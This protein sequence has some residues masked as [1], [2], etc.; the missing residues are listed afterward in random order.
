MTRA[1]LPPFAHTVVACLEVAAQGQRSK[2]TGGNAQAAF[3]ALTTSVLL[4]AN[5]STEPVGARRRKGGVGDHLPLQSV[6]RRS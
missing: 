3:G 1:Q 4:L 6:Q 5:T 2:T